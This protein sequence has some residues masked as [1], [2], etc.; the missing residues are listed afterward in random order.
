M[1]MCVKNINVI[2][3][4][5]IFILAFG[6]Q[7][8][9]EPRPFKIF[10][11]VYRI[12]SVANQV[13]FADPFYIVITKDSLF[14]AF[15]YWDYSHPYETTL[16]IND[17]LQVSS[18]EEEKYEIEPVSEGFWLKISGARKHRYSVVT[19]KYDSA[20]KHLRIMK[21]QES[22]LLGTWKVASSE[23]AKS[24]ILR[25]E[26]NSNSILRFTRWDKHKIVQ[27]ENM[28]GNKLDTCLRRDFRLDGSAVLIF[29]YD[30]FPPFTILK[31]DKDN[32]ILQG[33]GDILSFQKEPQ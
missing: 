33:P 5:S 7:T 18:A 22:L 27:V 11:H 16:K 26:L 21:T 32:L 29:E 10:G 4:L 2:I 23:T 12:D 28:D 3:F 1:S 14:Q 31:L 13:G 17:S 20:Y 8:K 24:D 15:G 6:C 19:K 30:G 9:S 25:C